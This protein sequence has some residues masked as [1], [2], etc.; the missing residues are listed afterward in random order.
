MDEF[1]E[2]NRKRLLFAG[3]AAILAAGVGFAIRGGIIDNW[4][5]EFGFTSLQIGAILGAGFTGFCFGIILGGLVVDKIGY[6]KLVLLAL[7]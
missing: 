2:Y 1:N 4:G 5:A 7:I 3:F 6:A